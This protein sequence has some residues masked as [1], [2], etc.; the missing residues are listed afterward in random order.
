MSVPWNVRVVE[1]VPAKVKE[2]LDVKVFPSATVKVALVAGAVMESLLTDVAEAAPILGVVKAGLV[3]NTAAPVPCSSERAPDKLADE[4]EPL[5]SVKI[6][7][8]ALGRVMVRVPEVEAPV[9]KKL[10]VPGVPEVPESL[11]S[12]QG[13]ALVPKS[14]V[15][16][17]PATKE[18][19]M[20]TEAK[21]D[22]EVL[23]PF[24]VVK[25]VPVESGIVQVRLAVRS[26]LVRVPVKA[27]AP[28][29]AGARE[30]LSELAVVLP[31]TAVPVP[32][33][34]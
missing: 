16:T 11:I 22:K 27:L 15:P 19:F 10:L 18:A 28:P 34:V 7:P 17:V 26:E 2:L 14:R 6:V 25:R 8:L 29:V 3:A 1:S 23:A 4:M 21:L 30:I 20:A 24:P 32:F 12:C 13:L 31:K 33:K 5:A 9:I